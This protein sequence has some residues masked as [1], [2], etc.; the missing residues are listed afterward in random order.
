MKE[1]GLQAGLRVEKTLVLVEA[2]P[3]F[4][5]CLFSKLLPCL[6]SHPV[7]VCLCPEEQVQMQELEQEKEKKQE[8]EQEQEQEVRENVV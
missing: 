3:L 2:S 5:P 4:L 7:S 8:Q 1:E 6:F